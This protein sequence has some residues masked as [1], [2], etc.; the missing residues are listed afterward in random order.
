[1]ER[2]N[3][4]GKLNVKR[5]AI[6]SLSHLCIF[7]FSLSVEWASILCE[8][9]GRV[10]NASDRVMDKV[11]DGKKKRDIADMLVFGGTRSC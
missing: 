9:N 8:K 7:F 10:W 2:H 4:F 3:G 11:G 1:M 5:R 6:F